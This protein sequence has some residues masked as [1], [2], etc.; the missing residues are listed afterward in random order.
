MTLFLSH[1]GAYEYGSQLV[2]A[3]SALKSSSQHGLAQVNGDSILLEAVWK[4]FCRCVI[5]ER[6]RLAKMK[7]FYKGADEVRGCT[8]IIVCACVCACV[9]ARAD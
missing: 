9:C 8:I 2:C 4:K 7:E 3:A 1:Q 6:K 5:G